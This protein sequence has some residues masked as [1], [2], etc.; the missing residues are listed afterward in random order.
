MIMDAISRVPADFRGTDKGRAVLER[1]L[2]FLH[3]EIIPME[4]DAGLRWGDVVEKDLLQKVWK[5]SA[6]AGHY[7]L[8][9]PEELGGAGLCLRDV[10]AVKEAAIL[11]GSIL[12]THVQG[13]FSGP[14]RIGHLFKSASPDQVERFLMP[15]CRAEQAV[16]FALTEPDSGSDAA[17]IQTSAVREGD[18]YVINGYKRFITG[19]P[20]ADFAILMAVTD[21]DKG[22]KGISAFFVDLHAEGVEKRADYDVLSAQK[23]HADLIFKDVKIPAANLIGEEGT[24]FY[25]GMSRITMNRLL[26]CATMLGYAQ[27]ALNHSIDHAN[28]RNQ[29]GMSIGSFQAIQHMLADMA[30]ELYA[31]R[32]MM[33]DAADRHDQGHDIR[34]ESSMCKVNTAETA[35]T[36]VDRAMQIHGGKGLVQGS[37]TEYLFRFIR[38]YRILTGT[39]EIQRNTIAKGLLKPGRN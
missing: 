33:F 23:S 30:T 14:P 36:V 7:T 35:F 11:S 25:L 16:C 38:M 4:Q 24:G 37:L 29:F 39:S 12:A 9:L 20:Y 17:S 32:S 13:E 18:H 22:A 2:E 1:L 31:S 19:S 8:L 10:V 21:P 6:D 27:L 26:H 3:T 5:K 28:T 15:V 34:M